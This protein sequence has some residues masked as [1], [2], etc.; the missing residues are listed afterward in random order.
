MKADQRFVTLHIYKVPPSPPPPPA[1][2]IFNHGSCNP[3]VFI[4]AED[5]KQVS[6][7][8]FYTRK[9]FKFV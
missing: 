7:R 9:L 4:S 6:H 8:Q 3:R 1:Y 5:M 2:L